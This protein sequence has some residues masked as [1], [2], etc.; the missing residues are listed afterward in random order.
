MQA[1]TRTPSDRRF[2][3]SGTAV[4]AAG[5][6]ALG[7]LGMTL[8]RLR[9]LLFDQRLAQVGERIGHRIDEPLQFALPC[10][11]SHPKLLYRLREAFL[12]AWT[13]SPL[14]MLDRPRMPMLAAR[15]TSSGL[16]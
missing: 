3:G 13:S 7:D 1:S 15:S 10:E 6:A 4:N 2:L 11:A 5:V 12:I 9:S 14:V 8:V 16:L